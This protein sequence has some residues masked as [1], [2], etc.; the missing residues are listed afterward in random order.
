MHTKR[1][2]IIDDDGNTHNVSIRQRESGLYYAIQY[3]SNDGGFNVSSDHKTPEQAIEDFAGTI[4]SNC[5]KRFE[6]EV[7]KELQNAILA[8]IRRYFHT[9]TKGNAKKYN[10]YFLKHVVERGVEEYVSNGQLKGAMKKL[11]YA[12]HRGC[13][14]SDINYLYILKKIKAEGVV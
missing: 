1:V 2:N 9:G 8:Y 4:N 13:E 10:S 7:S 11:G 3:Y 5:A 6:D 14:L 12:I